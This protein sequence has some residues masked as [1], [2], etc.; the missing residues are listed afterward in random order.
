MGMC[1]NV[2]YACGCSSQVTVA[3][4]TESC[5]G[6]AATITLYTKL[7]PYYELHGTESAKSEVS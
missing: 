6:V 5:S 3:D 4:L 2:V 1:M 7:H